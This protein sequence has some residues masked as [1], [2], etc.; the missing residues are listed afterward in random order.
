MT[1]LGRWPGGRALCNPLPDAPRPAA[2]PGV[3]YRFHYFSDMP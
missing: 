1:E 3:V 2:G